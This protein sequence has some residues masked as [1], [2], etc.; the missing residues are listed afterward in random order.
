MGLFHFVVVESRYG[1]RLK[2]L[3]FGLSGCNQSPQ[4]GKGQKNSNALARE[5]NW[6]ESGRVFF[7]PVARRA[8]LTCCFGQEKGECRTCDDDGDDAQV[9]GDNACFPE[10]RRDPHLEPIWPHVVKNR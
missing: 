6:D 4:R 9:V 10:F 5:N 1:A 2:L 8:I 3:L 7:P